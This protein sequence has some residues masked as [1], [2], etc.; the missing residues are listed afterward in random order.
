VD[1]EDARIEE[2]DKVAADGIGTLVA[3][4]VKGLI[5]AVDIGG[6][7]SRSADA[8]HLRTAGEAGAIRAVSNDPHARG[9]P[10]NRTARQRVAARQMDTHQETGDG[11][12]GH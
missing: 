2:A 12:M 4:C 6:V 7:A 10:A 9:V 5:V 8:G 1:G 11:R 3:L